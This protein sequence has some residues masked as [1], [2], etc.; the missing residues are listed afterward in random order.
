MLIYK[1]RYCGATK[2]PD[3]KGCQCGASHASL[4]IVNKQDEL[5]KA[6]KRAA[7]TGNRKDLQDYLKMRRIYR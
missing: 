4:K 6:A 3:G 1:C 2:F 7:R 5:E